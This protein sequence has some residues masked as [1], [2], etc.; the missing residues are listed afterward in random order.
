[1]R[2]GCDR[3]STHGTIDELFIIVTLVEEPSSLASSFGC[4]KVGGITVDVEDH[5]ACIIER[6]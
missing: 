4:K 1:M 3:L 6:G 5:I 2:E